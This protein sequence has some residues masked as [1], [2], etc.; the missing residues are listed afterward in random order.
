MEGIEKTARKLVKKTDTT[1]R[2]KPQSTM[3]VRLMA[4]D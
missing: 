3:T 1:L 2:D 4:E